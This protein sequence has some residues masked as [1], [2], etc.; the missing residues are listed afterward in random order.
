MRRDKTLRVGLLALL[1]LLQ[2]LPLLL[3]L[4]VLCHLSN[5]HRHA[6]PLSLFPLAPNGTRGG[7]NSQ[8]ECGTS[9]FPRTI[10]VFS[11]SPQTV[12]GLHS[13]KRNR[14]P[15]HPTPLCGFSPHTH[16]HAGRAGVPPPLFLSVSTSFIS[17]LSPS[18]VISS[19]SPPLPPLP[20]SLLFLTS[21]NERRLAGLMCT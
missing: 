20:P 17:L 13:R 3:L 21:P 16:T 11:T 7:E 10:P 19:N 15:L 18:L 12:L 2:L 9:V 6:P 5:P 4:P 14:G 8:Q 1:H